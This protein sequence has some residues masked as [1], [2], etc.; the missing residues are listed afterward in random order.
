MVKSASQARRKRAC[1]KPL[2]ETRAH[3]HPF[4]VVKGVVGMR[5]ISAQGP[6][7]GSPD[8]GSADQTSTAGWTGDARIQEPRR[9]G[10]AAVEEEVWS[11]EVEVLAPREMG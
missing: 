6:R 7:F 10:L 4:A 9:T 8:L 3:Q 1:T 5:D 2:A 11:T